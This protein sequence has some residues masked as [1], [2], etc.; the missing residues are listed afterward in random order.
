MRLIAESR[1]ISSI[2]ASKDRIKIKFIN[3]EH[4]TIKT[5]TKL[6][7]FPSRIKEELLNI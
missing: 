3:K 1:S 5:P 7:D 6:E 2:Q 4:T